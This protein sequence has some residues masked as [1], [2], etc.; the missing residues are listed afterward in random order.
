MLGE[1]L[2]K[3][4]GPAGEGPSLRCFHQY[5]TEMIFSV[6]QQIKMMTMITVLLLVDSVQVQVHQL[7][8]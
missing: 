4:K 3:L 1:N 5:D 8:K 7:Q 6:M 2:I